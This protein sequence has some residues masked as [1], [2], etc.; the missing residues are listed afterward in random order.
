MGLLAPAHR[1]REPALTALAVLLLAV[2]LAGPL[3]AQPGHCDPGLRPPEDDFYGYRL[4]GDR[5]EGIYVKDVAGTALQIV[6][7]TESV[8]DF[9]PTAGKNLLV[10][11]TAPAEAA[12]RLRALA[13]RPGLYYQMDSLRP[14]GNASYGWS[15]NFLRELKLKKGE[16]GLLAWASQ[17]TGDG[18]R[19]VYLPLRI[20]QLAAPTRTSRYSVVVRPEVAVNDLYLSL[21]KDRDGRPGPAVVT[22]QPIKHGYS[23]AGEVIAISIPALT[24]PGVYYLE[25]GATLKAGGSSVARLWLYHPGA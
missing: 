16:L 1:H 8:E 12:V 11:W 21:A 5:C 18:E 7:L 9:N 23:P 25:I 6:S 24:A 3:S 14:A 13:L 22:D 20:S 17:R 10:Q 4:R 15:P 2:T 19:R